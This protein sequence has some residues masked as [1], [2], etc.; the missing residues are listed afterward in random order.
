MFVLSKLGAGPVFWFLSDFQ[1]IAKLKTL[2]NF[3]KNIFSNNTSM[4][5]KFGDN[6]S[7][8]FQ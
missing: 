1:N 5:L 4:P 2:L 3:L 8:H 7:E 6:L